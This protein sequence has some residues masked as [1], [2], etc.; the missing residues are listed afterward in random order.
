MCIVLLLWS[1]VN[2]EWIWMNQT[3]K[4]MAPI[5]MF[6]EL[7]P[8][9]NMQ[10]DWLL[11]RQLSHTWN[12]WNVPGH[13]RRVSSTNVLPWIQKMKLVINAIRYWIHVLYSLVQIAHGEVFSSR[14]F[15]CWLCCLLLKLSNKRP[16]SSLSTLLLAEF[17]KLQEN[18]QRGRVKNK[19]NKNILMNPHP[20]THL[21]INVTR[22]TDTRAR[23]RITAA[24]TR[25]KSEKQLVCWFVPTWGFVG[26]LTFT[27][28]SLGLMRLVPVLVTCDALAQFHGAASP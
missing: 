25:K 27:F 12:A 19:N 8:S 26:R 1:S 9:F 20:L 6:N 7:W 22:I 3:N 13:I 15:K 16:S 24:E 2:Y 14:K 11:T 4:K 18:W 23:L 28:S 17:V 21:L 10:N 5:K